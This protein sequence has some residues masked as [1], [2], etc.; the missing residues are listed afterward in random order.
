MLDHGSAAFD[1][2]A[3]VDVAGVHVVADRR[4]MDMPADHAVHRM[5]PRLADQRALVL[6][7][8][9]HGVLD[10]ELEPLRQRPVRIAQQA[11]RGVEHA[12]EPKRGLVGMIAEV[13]EPAG[14]LDHHVEVIAVDDKIALAVA[15]L[16]DRGFRNLDPAEMVAVVVSQELVV[17]AR[18][19]HD[20]RALAGEAQELLHDVVMGLRPVPAVFELPAV[21]DVTDEIDHVG[22][23]IAQEVEQ[24]LG[25]AAL[26]PEMNVGDEEGVESGTTV[27]PRAVFH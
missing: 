9:V 24:P 14:V 18:H 27:H 5:A 26:G 7:D 19:V 10:L 4:V 8:V 13:G 11:A 16:M 3:A 17:V 1:P 22:L 2:V 15:G 20:A 23:M 21:H 25:L 6:A 12:I